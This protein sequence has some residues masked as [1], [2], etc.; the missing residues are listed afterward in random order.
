MPRRRVSNPGIPLFYVC[1]RCG[2]DYQEYGAT[3]SVCPDCL[4]EHY[5]QCSECGR[6]SLRS[7][8]APQTVEEREICIQCFTNI[9]FHCHHC[10]TNYFGY[11]RER[12]SLNGLTY[13]DI[14]AETEFTS[15]SCCG[16]DYVRDALMENEYGQ[17]VCDECYDNEEYSENIHGYSFKPKPIF[18]RTKSE[19]EHS[20]VL[21]IELEM[22][23]I[24]SNSLAFEFNKEIGETLIY[25][26]YDSTIG[27]GL[28]L[29][30][31]PISPSLL[32]SPKGRNTIRK[33]LDMAL[34]AEMISHD[35]GTC[36]FH[37]HI[38]RDFFGLSKT[39]YMVTELKFTRLF[40]RFYVPI[41][42]F[43]RRKEAE[44]SRWADK[45]NFHMR[46]SDSWIK[47]ASLAS[48]YIRTNRYVA[49]NTRNDDTIEIRIFRGS[50]KF[51][52]ILATIQFTVGICYY[53]RQAKP[54]EIERINWYELCDEIVNHCPYSTKELSEYLFE[55]E[56]AVKEA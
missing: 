51:S 32:L 25:S 5:F 15:C 28:E 49:V 18:H 37:I 14:C 42:L 17:M 16:H 46:K 56:L 7:D 26:K 43:A 12:I 44:A 40:D 3:E 2:N 48:T 11:N 38:N 10:E 52:T 50:L 47:N 6:Y 24:R 22:Q 55:R 21:G 29:V 8:T 27:G 23:G 45:T 54:S 19:S 4:S 41:R 1:S 35:A 34:E 20:L 33:I 30:T 36:G 31:H 13:C 9:T 39:A 53:I